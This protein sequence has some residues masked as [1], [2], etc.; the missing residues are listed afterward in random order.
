MYIFLRIAVFCIILLTPINAQNTNKTNVNK[1]SSVIDNIAGNRKT[2]STSRSDK[3]RASDSDSTT[4]TSE[5]DLSTGIP[6]TTN[7]F[8]NY[9]NPMLRSKMTKIMEKVDQVNCGEDV[10]RKF[11]KLYSNNQELFDLCFVDSNYQIF[12]VKRKPDAKEIA[13]MCNSKNCRNL[14]SGIILS[15]FEECDIQS[16]S[17]R[18]ISEVMFRIKKKIDEGSSPPSST[19][20]EDLYNMNRIANL[21]VE[22]TTLRTSIFEDSDTKESMTEM[23]KVMNEVKINPNV[24]LGDDNKIIILE[25]NRNTSTMGGDS[26]TGT[27]TSSGS[28]RANA[29]ERHLLKYLNFFLLFLL[30]VQFL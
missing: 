13:L 14:L 5:S 18:T 19:Q 22:N 11:F 27:L 15:K 28:S 24:R 6:S 30:T 1:K 29:S 10:R 25:E 23:I 7:A 2:L 4:S 20:F 12:P 9:V 16:Y 26:A 17:I 21:L 3:L 8:Q